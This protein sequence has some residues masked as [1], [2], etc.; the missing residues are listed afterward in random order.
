MRQIESDYMVLEDLFEDQESIYLV[1]RDFEG[2]ILA[3][4]LKQKTMSLDEL[5][6]FTVGFLR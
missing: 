3:D 1:V 6:R 5:A 4:Y 2:V